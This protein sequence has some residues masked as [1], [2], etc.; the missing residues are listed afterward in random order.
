MTSSSPDVPGRL[1]LQSDE[2]RHDRAEWERAAAAVL[3]KARRMSEEDPDALVWEKLARTT[4]DGIVVPPVGSSAD[5]EALT[6]SGRPER[7]GG[8]DVRVR[9]GGGD[10]AA[11]NRTLL[12]ELS[13]G[14]TSLWLRIDGSPT[15]DEL[16]ALLA[17]VRLELA[18][19]VL[20]APE[21]PVGAGAALAGLLARRGSGVAPGTSVGADP[22]GSALGSGGPQ[23]TEAALAETVAGVLASARDAGVAALVVDATVVHDLGASDGQELGYSLAV[24]AAYLRALVAAGAGLE[25]ALGLLEFRYAV[26]D[27]QFPGIAKLRAARRCWARVAELSGA[28]AEAAGQRQHAVTSRPMMSKYD[29][30]VNML[31][32]TVAAFAAGVGGADSVT[33]LPFDSPL[34]APDD[35]GRRI[36]RNTTALLVEEAHLAVVADPGGGSYAVERLTDDLGHAGWA[37]FQRLEAAGGVLAA[38]ADGSLRSRIGEVAARR[39]DEV[40]RRVRPITGLSEFPNLDE[41]LP[42]RGGEPDQVRRYGAA[43]EALRDAPAGQPVF[44]ATLG[45]VAAHTARAMYATNLL[46]AGGVAVEAAGPTNGVTDVLAAYTGQPVVCLAGP[47]PAYAE[48]GADLVA[49]LR[50]AGAR[51]VVLAGKPGDRT[52]AAD[53]LDDACS[54]GQ[55][56]LAFLNRTRT[57]LEAAR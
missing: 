42:E 23:P 49:G 32:T 53:L 24:G 51:H 35:L 9:A 6:T 31:R 25:E 2:D 15:V 28:A 54:L 11:A 13:T 14:A 41:V 36:A 1:P 8:W 44:L 19:V 3:R 57:A 43:F 48:W 40:A 16:D 21:D 45:S 55:D 20:D 37:E 30:Y 17:E 46:A 50:A 12:Q 22:I 56:A 39:D 4:L 47:D 26:T 5:L 52:I 33:V 7:A 27:E 29:P 38:L 10:A 18:A 34:G